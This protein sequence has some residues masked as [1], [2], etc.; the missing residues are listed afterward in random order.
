MIYYYY[1][2][3]LKTLLEIIESNFK[4]LNSTSEYEEKIKK[5]TSWAYQS[6]IKKLITLVFKKS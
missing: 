2:E 3:Q 4:F 6:K 5:L 1:Y